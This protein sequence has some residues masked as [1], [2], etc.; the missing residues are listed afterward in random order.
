M[1]FISLISLLLVVN[2]STTHISVNVAG[3]MR[4][5]M[6]LGDLSPVI[7]IDT[8]LKTPNLYGIGAA[9]GL[10]GEIMILNGR[11]YIS[12]IE[13][14]RVV[15]TETSKIEAS[16]LVYSPVKE[17]RTFMVSDSILNMQALQVSIEKIANENGFE[18]P[19]PFL[20][21]VKKG[22]TDYHIIEWKDGVPHTMSNHKQ[23][24]KSGTLENEELQILGF[25]SRDHKGIFTHHDS[26]I[27][28]HFINV[29][30]SLVGHV[31][32]LFWAKGYELRLPIR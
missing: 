7:S 26:N 24:A 1:K 15:T 5:I 21:K 23:Y 4:R 27:H 10:H 20:L 11:S 32:D 19:F 9:G 18:Q 17:W 30:Q 14:D 29:S 13:K 22:K 16:L 28:A 8:I 6:Q 2:G 3:E 12:A 25:Y 31:D